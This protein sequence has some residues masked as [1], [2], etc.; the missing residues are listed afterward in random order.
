MGNDFNDRVMSAPDRDAELARI[1]RE[2]ALDDVQ[3][4]HLRDAARADP[5]AGAPREAAGHGIADPVVVGE[6]QVGEAGHADL[7]LKRRTSPLVSRSRPR[8]CHE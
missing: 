7:G 3:L 8:G 5:I 1:A 6:A 2:L 4:E